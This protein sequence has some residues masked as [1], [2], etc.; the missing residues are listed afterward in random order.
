MFGN[1]TLESV[2]AF[3]RLSVAL[4]CCWPLRSTATKSQVIRF[5][6]FRFT[7]IL[8]A[9]V[10][11][12]PLLNALYVQRDNASN[13]AQAACL[14]LAVVQLLMQTAFCITQYDRLQRLIEEM[15]AHCERAKQYE[16]Q[17]F[18]HYVQKYCTFYGVSAIWFYVSASVFVVGTVFISQ[19]FPTNAEYPFAVDYEPLRTIIFLH[20][21][22][23]GMQCAAHVCINLLGALLL[24]Y[25]AARF[26]ILMMELRDITD[27]HDL[28][29][30]VNKYCSTKRYAQE[31]VKSVG[32]IALI[33]IGICGVA[34]VL[35]GI[36]FIGRQP[37][38]VK[39]QFLCLTGTAL[40]EVFMCAWPAD[41]L[42]D[43]SE[44]VVQ[45]AYQSMW[46]ERTPKM[47]KNVLYMLIP[48][49]AVAI[50]IKC[51]IPVLSLN[52]YCSY[53]SNVFS[54][55]TALRIMMIKYEDD[56]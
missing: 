32:C 4:T 38:T 9:F 35:C 16:I 19:P 18:Q 43:T 48:K 36:N 52:Y 51:I 22:L 17:V 46:Y 55:F 44:N 37:F 28:I 25:A 45:G 14:A 56:S 23:V 6:I 53:I 5:K 33:T 11:F 7:M 10:L 47:Q 27:I 50:R 15:I 30:G 8:N 2:I 42:I 34:L 41:H 21:A 29:K 12:L 40:L 31:V 54:L 1:V 13:F 49:R 26:E 39:M 20:Q 3:T 24:F